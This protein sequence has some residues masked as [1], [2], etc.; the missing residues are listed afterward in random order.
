MLNGTMGFVF[1]I[2]YCFCITNLEAVVMSKLPFPFVDV[3]LA[4][5]NSNAGTVYMVTIPLILSVC[6][7]F[8]ALAAASRQAWMLSRNQALPFSQSLHK[9]VIIGIPVPLNSILFSLS[10]LVITT[11]INIESTATLNTITALLTAATSIPHVLS[12][13]CILLKRLKGEHLPPS[14]LSLGRIAIPCN[15]L[16]LGYVITAVVAS[17][18]PVTVPKDA[19]NMNWSS[20]ILSAVLS[21]A[22]TDYLVRGRKHYIELVRQSD[23]M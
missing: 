19:E 8:N 6:M 16:A 21:I 3:F 23:K 14:H 12:I 22:C 2:T 10:V 4:A 9:I 5:T 7:S 20:L 17:F 13:S 15:T 1:I 18:F 11:L